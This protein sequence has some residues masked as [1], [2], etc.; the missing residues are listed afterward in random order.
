MSTF[1]S[2][3]DAAPLTKILSAGINNLDAAVATAFGL[4][5]DETKLK[6]GTVQHAVDS[7][8][9][10][11]YVV[12]LTHTPG[13]YTD[14][15]RISMRPANTNTG[16]STINVNALGIKSIRRVD[17]T[18]TPAGSIMVG[19]P[20]DLV[21]SSS[22][23]YFHIIGALG[24][25]GYTGTLPVG[26][27][28]TGQSSFTNGQLLIGNTTGNTLDKATLTA[29]ANITVNNGAGS[30]EIV[31]AG[32][33]STVSVAS[34]NG[35]AGSV[36]TATSTPAITLTTTTT[37]LLKGNGTAIAAA[38]SGTDIKTIASQSLIGSG[39][40]ALKTVNSTSLIGAGDIAIAGSTISRTARTG[41]TILAAADRGKFF[42]VTSGTFSQTFVAAAT[43]TDGWFCWYRNSGTGVVTLDPDGVELID[44]AAT[45]TVRTGETRLIQC[46]GTALTTVLTAKE[47]GLVLLYTASP[48][49]AAT[50]DFTGIGSTHDEFEIHVQNLIPATNGVRL[51]LTGSNDNG[52]TWIAGA[53]YHYTNIFATY[54]GA[55]S[56]EKVTTDAK[57]IVSTSG[58]STITNVATAARARG[59][60]GVIKLINPAASRYCDVLYEGSH[61]N[62]VTAHI[63]V[64][65]AGQIDAGSG[66]LIDAIRLAFSAGNIASGEVKLYGLR[67]A[68]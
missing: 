17:S 52:S 33:V 53:D 68:V 10:D 64:I 31:G 30:I 58:G 51:H 27:G 26:S 36:A 16:A 34:A 14:G 44:G 48:S 12:T 46:T 57:I 9:A 49:S 21:Y 6:L 7:G 65:G 24:A 15:M 38:V 3:T 1:T 60:S 67:K 41:N 61:K 8:A 20:I 66:E 19:S 4:L 32:S 54:A 45:G 11:A 59:W 55:S 2:P 63:P 47:P 13:S 29:G 35:F 28:G 62:D 42:D 25:T 23:G 56:A 39:D 40:V 50:V 18:A 5:P 43:L 22:T 37:G